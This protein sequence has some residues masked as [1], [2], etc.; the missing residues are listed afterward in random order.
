MYTTP[1]YLCLCPTLAFGDRSCARGYWLVLSRCWT[2]ASSETFCST[3]MDDLSSSDLTAILSTSQLLIHL[4]QHSSDIAVCLTPKKK[5]EKTKREIKPLFWGQTTSKRCSSRYNRI[6]TI[7]V[8]TTLGL[9]CRAHCPEYLL[10]LT[11]YIFE[12]TGWLT[13]FPREWWMI[14]CSYACSKYLLSSISSLIQ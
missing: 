11:W 7:I 4:V 12:S 2:L 10:F 3:L 1:K 5:A 8:I 13:L 6:I 9:C 14:Y